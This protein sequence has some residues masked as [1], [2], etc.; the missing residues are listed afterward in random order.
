MEKIKIITD[1]DIFDS[2]LDRHLMET[3]HVCRVL[4]SLRKVSGLLS[5]SEKYSTHFLSDY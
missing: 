3:D 1:Q 5:N 4:S 2:S